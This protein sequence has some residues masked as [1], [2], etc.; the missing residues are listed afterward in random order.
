V[1]RF[2]AQPPQPL[3][4]NAQG[5]SL[6]AEVRCAMN[7][8]NKLEQLC[9]YITRPAIANDRLQ[10]N[11]AGDVVLQLKSP[12]RDGTTHIVMTPLEFMQRLAALVPRPRLNL[13]RFHGVLAPNA[14][15]RPQ[16]IPGRADTANNTSDE[17]DGAPHHARSARMSWARLLKRVFDIDVEHCPHCGG[18][19][20]IIS[21]IEEPSVIARILT[22]LGLSTRAPPRSPARSFDF[23]ETA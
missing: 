9:R 1:P 17:L 4:A 12:Y 7:Q 16:I 10:F 22:H 13:I 8:R 21:A 2:D 20:K 19:L 6:H 5:F 11:R 23:L 18:N 15:L 14:K 3:C